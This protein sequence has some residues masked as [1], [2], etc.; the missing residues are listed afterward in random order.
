MATSY[1]GLFVSHEGTALHLVS[2]TG[3][4]G[5]TEDYGAITPFASH[6]DQELAD[7]MQAI[8]TGSVPTWPY[9]HAGTMIP[10]PLQGR[11]NPE[12]AVL[13]NW[14][15][16][17]NRNWLPGCPNPIDENVTAIRAVGLTCFEENDDDTA[18]TGADIYTWDVG[19]TI[20]YMSP[21][22]HREPE[23]VYALNWMLD[24]SGNFP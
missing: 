21:L 24:N 16:Q 20:P 11:T 6:L 9:T 22:G 18:L 8:Y 7:A 15:A 19:G 4:G 14:I 3:F 2:G 5:G 23:F 13:V 1:E 12:V 10:V 17:R